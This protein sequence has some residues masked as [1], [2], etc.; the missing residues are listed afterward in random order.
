MSSGIEL[1][2]S[3]SSSSSSPSSYCSAETDSS[4]PPHFSSSDWANSAS[5]FSAADRDSIKQTGCLGIR[6]LDGST[7][8][9]LPSLEDWQD[10][11]ETCALQSLFKC[12]LTTSKL[13]TQLCQPLPTG[14]NFTLHFKQTPK[15]SLFTFWAVSTTTTT[16]TS[17]QPQP[18]HP[19]STETCLHYG[20]FKH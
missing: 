7:Y 10:G 15:V 13:Q 9:K 17:R 5:T 4:E 16:T 20:D 18:H 1:S 14:N 11:T 6:L 19:S 2:P 12:C 3:A 8:S